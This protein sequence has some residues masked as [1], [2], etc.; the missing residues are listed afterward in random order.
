MEEVIIT[1]LYY[2][3]FDFKTCFKLIADL[4]LDMI[5]FLKYYQLRY[6]H[7]MLELYI[8]GFDAF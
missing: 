3:Y 1:S 8:L 7:P 6:L 4:F 5:F 2:H